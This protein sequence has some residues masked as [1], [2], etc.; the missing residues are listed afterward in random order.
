MYRPGGGGGQ[1]AEIGEGV[2]VGPGQQALGPNLLC[3]V[4]ILYTVPSLSLPLDKIFIDGL[5]SRVEPRE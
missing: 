2:A 4:H 3:T 5:L 1:G